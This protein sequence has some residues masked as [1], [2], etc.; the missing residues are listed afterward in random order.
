[1]TKTITIE[2]LGT[3]QPAGSKRGF[4]MKR[5]GQGWT[6]ANGKFAGRVII[7][8]NNPKARDWRITASHAASQA[9]AA[10][11]LPFERPLLDGPLEVSM[12]FRMPRLAS[13]RRSN[14]ELKPNAPAR[15]PVRPDVLKLARGTEDALTGIVWRD[16]AQI[17][18]ERLEKVYADQPGATIKVS[19]LCESEVKATS[20]KA[21]ELP[22]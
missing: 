7:T 11:Q 5:K 1:M 3:P 10:A 6:D 12:V 9:M 4:P 13:H 2:V 19:E 17:V 22:I 15:P 18:I 8:D 20:A 16:D 14:G 21:L